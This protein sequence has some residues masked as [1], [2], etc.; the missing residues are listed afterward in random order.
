[1]SVSFLWKLMLGLLNNEAIVFKQI[2][3]LSCYIALQISSIKI[4]KPVLH[5]LQKLLDGEIFVSF[6]ET[7][8]CLKSSTFL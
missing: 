2:G 3:N 5:Q 6:V 1:M 7:M 4:I 8:A